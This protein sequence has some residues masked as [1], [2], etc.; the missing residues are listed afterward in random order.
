MAETYY[1][2]D[3]PQ[4]MV[5]IEFV[6]VAPALRCN[7]YGYK[8]SD[9]AFLEVYVDGHRFRIDVGNVQRGDGTTRRG[10]HICG[11]IDMDVDKHSVNACDVLI[12]QKDG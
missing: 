3:C 2:K 12:P 5:Q 11:P 10:L 1:G 6:G 9:S 4:G 7:E 8:P